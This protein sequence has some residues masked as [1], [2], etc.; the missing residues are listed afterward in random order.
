MSVLIG[1]G[2]DFL[3]ARRRWLYILLRFLGFQYNRNERFRLIIWHDRRRDGVHLETTLLLF[4]LGVDAQRTRSFQL[5][6]WRRRRVTAIATAEKS[7]C[8]SDCDRRHTQEQADI[9]MQHHMSL[10]FSPEFTQI[11]R[12]RFF[13]EEFVLRS[14]TFITCLFENQHESSL[15]IDLVFLFLDFKN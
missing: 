14:I 3:T 15:S 2:G 4:L 13:K 8:L 6:R 9:N 1:T 11:C 10:C 7:T 12:K 5:Q